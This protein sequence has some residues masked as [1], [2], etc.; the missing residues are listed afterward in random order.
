MT[1]AIDGLLGAETA[2]DALVERAGDLEYRLVTRTV[3]PPQAGSVLIDRHGQ[4]WRVMWSMMGWV[5]LTNGASQTTTRWWRRFQTGQLVLEPQ[6]PVT[7]RPIAWMAYVLLVAT[8]LLLVVMTTVMSGVVGVET[9]GL[10]MLVGL[11]LMVAAYVATTM[12][13]RAQWSTMVHALEALTPD[14]MPRLSRDVAGP[15]PVVCWIFGVMLLDQVWPLAPLAW[16]V[17]GGLAVFDLLPTRHFRL[18]RPLTRQAMQVIRG[19][20]RTQEARLKHILL[21]HD[22]GLVMCADVEMSGLLAAAEYWVDRGEPITVLGPAP[23]FLPGTLR[24]NFAWDAS[25][26]GA[27]HFSV[28]MELVGLDGWKSRFGTDLN[29]QIGPNN[30]G[31]S[32]SESARL[33]IARALAQGAE[34]LVLVDALAPLSAVAQRDVLRRLSALNIL[35]VVCSSVQ[36]LWEDDGGADG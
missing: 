6:Q 12:I 36:D 30:R 13:H 5:S 22:R 15:I 9:A 16:I 24:A 17:V 10:W 29:Y 32:S 20:D 8:R 11:M 2:F 35:V 1:L 14:W 7:Q 21:T 26:V 3:H 18:A 19:R 23:E 27:H 28:L 33:A 4:L 25:D 34:T 31:L